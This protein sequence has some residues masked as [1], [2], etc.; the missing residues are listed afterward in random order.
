MTV[1]QLIEPF[2]GLRIERIET[3]P[4]RV[5]LDKIY[6]GSK[7]SMQNRCTIVTRVYTDSGVVG[8]VYTG[9]TDKEQPDILAIIEKEL[10]PALIGRDA[11]NIE[12]CWEAM[13]P[14]TYDILRDRALALQAIACVD[15]ALWDCI[16]KALAMPL[17]KLWGGYRNS[18]PVIA[19]GGYYGQS[20]DELA[21]EVETY[22]GYG[23]CGMKFKVGGA[24]PQEDLTRLR[25]AQAAAPAGFT[26]MVD[27][28]QGYTLQ[29]A[30]TFVRMA[31]E[32]GIVLRWFEEPVRWYNDRRWLR[33]MRLMT[34]VPITAG[35]SEFTLN[36]I[37]DLIAD[38]AI[39]VSNFDS[40]WGGGPTIWR[41]A[42]A[43]AYAYGVEV[44]HHEEAHISS[45]LLCSQPHGTYAECFHAERDP[46]FWNIQTEARPIRDG[47]YYVSEKPGFGLSLDQDYIERFKVT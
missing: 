4:L 28:N 35:Q 15:T 13:R 24:T 22:V 3:I 11:F 12:G 47:V 20:L 9:D 40:S 36:G 38:G 31:R 8:E 19:I 21:H 14:A 1:E 32:A 27:A 41:K 26:F 42:A 29:D 16:G 7:Y 18:L 46:I 30:L 37:R 34:G 17:Y 6:R 43:L 23:V 2:R 45:H 39:D 10:V 25:A 5:P 44:G 33:D